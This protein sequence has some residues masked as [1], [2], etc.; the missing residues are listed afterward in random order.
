MSGDNSESLDEDDEY[1][2]ESSSLF[3]SRSLKVVV[4]SV[5]VTVLTVGADELRSLRRHKCSQCA[6]NSAAKKLRYAD[7][8]IKLL[9]T[10]CYLALK[11]APHVHVVLDDGVL[12]QKA[13]RETSRS[14][15][16][17]SGSAPAAVI[18]PSVATAAAAAAA[19][20]E[21]AVA[22]VSNPS[23]TSS[24]VP[25]LK[26][27]TSLRRV[28][29][30]AAETVLFHVKGVR[31]PLLVRIVPPVAA[32]LNS[33]DTFV[34]HSGNSAVV[35][36][37]GALAN[38]QERLRG[39]CLAMELAD[40]GALGVVV[41]EEAQTAAEFWYAL[42]G[43]HVIRSAAA[44]GDDAAV[45]FS[46]VLHTVVDGRL[47]ELSRGSL[48]DRSQLVATGV[49]VLETDQRVTVWLGRAAPS[50]L[51]AQAC[52]LAEQLSTRIGAQSPTVEED[53]HESVAFRAQVRGFENS[54]QR[55]KAK[56]LLQSGEL[57]WRVNTLHV[58]PP[59]VSDAAL[60]GFDGV[61]SAVAP[62]QEALDSALAAR[63]AVARMNVSG[64]DE[65]SVDSVLSTN[66][67]RTATLR[68]VSSAPTTPAPTPPTVGVR[69]DSLEPF[70]LRHRYAVRV[71]GAAVFGAVSDG[72]VAVLHATIV[73]AERLTFGAATI[74]LEAKSKGLLQILDVGSG[75]VKTLVVEQI[76][77]T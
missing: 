41:Y 48:P 29:P 56:K 74:Y 57:A 66:S 17:H 54:K 15:L 49:F 22:A 44:G 51:K 32:S 58:Q 39:L 4:P 62:R 68:H 72:G 63:K 50:A 35:V 67:S 45:H 71:R 5:A 26:S 30:P 55:A 69:L 75:G 77:E 12:E 13:R 7:E 25:T 34:L 46:H 23:P 36:W 8:S 24:A 1:S 37:N 47:G 52:K 2:S 18:V 43:S 73:C 11:S 38:K 9:C 64:A 6:A 42:G 20:E 76:V 53:G 70:D 60:V 65:A 33:G 19:V 3:D 16:Y 10:H 59:R 40:V 28:S 27:R 21:R 14:N 61:I 31:E